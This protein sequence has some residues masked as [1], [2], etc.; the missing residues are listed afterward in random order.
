MGQGTADLVPI[1]LLLLLTMTISGVICMF[2][3]LYYLRHRRYG[4][5]I[6]LS[7][8]SVRQSAGLVVPPFL[9]QRP[10]CW[11]AIRTRSQSRVEEVLGLDD[12][13]PCGWCEGLAGAAENRLFISP[14][15]KGWILVFGS[16]LPRPSHD[17]DQCYRFLRGISDQLGE[18]H[19]YCGDPVTHEHGW[20]RLVDG[21]V[22]RGYAWWQETV[23]NEGEVSE[24]ERRA[25]LAIFD[26][27]DAPEATRLGA[28]ERYRLNTDRLFTLAG[29]WSLDPSR[30]DRSDLASSGQGVSGILSR[31]VLE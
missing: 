28:Q 3:V 24:A 2:A 6:G 5:A 1:M 30:V 14:P 31:T 9:Y 19:F 16:D 13:N 20:A 25:S 17:V 8:P 26:Y 7:R 23:W 22:E 21:C 18:V 10:T 15:V 29:R 4:P 11:L 27:G 12:T